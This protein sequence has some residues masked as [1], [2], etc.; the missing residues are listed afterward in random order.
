MST[1]T[2]ERSRVQTAMHPRFRRRR[3]EVK[4][5]AGRRRLKIA[6]GFGVLLFLAAAAWGT[7]RSP[8]LDLDRIELSGIQR[9]SRAEV[10]AVAG[11]ER[12]MPLLDVDASAIERRLEA[13]SAVG[14]AEVARYFPNRVTIQLDERS[15]IAFVPAKSGWAKVDQAGRFIAISKERDEPLPAIAGLDPVDKG[16]VGGERA[17][18]GLAVAGA[19][20]PKVREQFDE[21][22]VESDATVTLLM[23][24]KTVID[25]GPATDL[26][27][28]MI[29][30]ET[31]LAQELKGVEKI[32][33]RVPSTPALTRKG[34]ATTVST[35]PRG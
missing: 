8:L 22:R 15:P 26:A 9:L 12:G 3:V 4:R 35:A 34:A 23:K 20:P 28:K 5:D 14:N 11:I 32:D 19:M 1:D 29:A 18:A 31:M 24:S 33:V 16:P 21:I 7:T 17:N 2:R 10:L 13:L 27:A 25:V 30:I 6:V